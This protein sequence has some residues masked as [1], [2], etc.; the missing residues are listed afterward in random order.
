LGG[1]NMNQWFDLRDRF[2]DWA[3]KEGCDQVRIF[4]R[5]GWARKLPDYKIQAYVMSKQL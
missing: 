5:K 3:R 1:D 2:E 4:A